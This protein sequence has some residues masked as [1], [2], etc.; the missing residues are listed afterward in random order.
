MGASKDTGKFT[1][2]LFA[3][4]E[5]ASLERRL[6]GGAVASF[7][8]RIS[9][10]GF[11][12]LIS[13]LLARSLGA[14]EYGVYAY[15]L[16]WVNTLC[17]LVL[18]G[19]DNVVVREVAAGQAQSAWGV[20]RGL[21]RW[22][23]LLVLAF[24][25]TVGLLAAVI[26]TVF[27]RRVNWP[28]LPAFL[29]ALT[30]L[31]LLALTRIRQATLQ[32]L[33]HVLASQIPEA[34][35]QPAIFISLILA[36]QWL[37]GWALQARTAVALYAI[38]ATVALLVGA[39]ILYSRLPPEAKLATPVY[40]SKEWIASALPLL[41]VNGT[42]VINTQAP[43]LLLGSMKDAQAAGLY[44]ISVRVADLL[45]FGLISVNFALAPVA[46]R[47]WAER[48]IARLQQVVTR[49]VRA[50]LCFTV[51]V[52]AIVIIFGGKILSIFGPGFIQA[53][54]ALTILV[55]GQLVNVTMGSVG[56]LLIM[57]GHEREVAIVTVVCA[58]L[59]IGL[60]LIM[61]PLWGL[62]GSALAVTIGIIAWNL[63]LVVLVRRR[64][65][66]HSTALWF[67]W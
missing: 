50:A 18:I 55:A 65:G 35:I 66:I 58:S 29:F 52:A 16:A 27:S 63:V 38:A 14:T 36:S 61:I 20:L 34:V 19:L 59:N 41:L 43:I 32:G 12:F 21:L 22:S 53:R 15:V 31:P 6:A 7:G 54:P 64:L 56:L 4:S 25:L 28:Y 26:A 5:T 23:N 47:L 57:T 2:A 11:S 44:A 46:A 1:R 37:W 33:Q 9:L 45:A 49:S 51:P 42:N 8:I 62:V 10:T 60:N 24:S 40:R 17:I 39:V 67:T 3:G 13:L 30:L 48:D